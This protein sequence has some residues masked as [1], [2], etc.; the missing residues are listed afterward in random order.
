MYVVLAAIDINGGK[1][2]GDVPETFPS[3]GTKEDQMNW[4]TNLSRAI[5][6]FCYTP[7]EP[8]DVN[9]A[10]VAYSKDATSMTHDM[11]EAGYCVCADAGKSIGTLYA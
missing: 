8:W 4:V 11:A 2:I 10:A 5:V 7:P 1:S 9:A 6:A 3:A